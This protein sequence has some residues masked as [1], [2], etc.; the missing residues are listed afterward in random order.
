MIRN[1]KEVLNRGL[2]AGK[3]NFI[4]VGLDSGDLQ[5]G[6]FFQQCDFIIER[7]VEDVL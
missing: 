1:N 4:F 6:E 3:Y 7:I 2:E 5:V